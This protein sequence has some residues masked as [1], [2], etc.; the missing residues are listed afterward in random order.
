MSEVSTVNAYAMSAFDGTDPIAGWVV[1][2]VLLLVVTLVAYA[3]LR[4]IVMVAR[5]ILMTVAEVWTNGQRVANNTIHIASL[6]RTRDAVDVIVG[7]AG[8]IA[9]HAKAIE[10][11]AKECAGCPSCFLKQ[12]G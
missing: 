5:G 6:Y 12:P 9:G 1:A 11:H 4:R 8:S 3:L 7:G 10:A 2:I